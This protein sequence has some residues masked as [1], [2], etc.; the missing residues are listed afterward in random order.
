MATMWGS[1]N[2]EKQGGASDTGGGG[3]AGN[4]DAQ[5]AAAAGFIADPAESAGTYALPAVGSFS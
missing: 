3:A 2:L 5:A 4:D 1:T